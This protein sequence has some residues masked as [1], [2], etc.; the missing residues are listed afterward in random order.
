VLS[1]TWP[2]N[3]WPADLRRGAGFES[4]QVAWPFG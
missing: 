4:L 2:A 1:R 3:A